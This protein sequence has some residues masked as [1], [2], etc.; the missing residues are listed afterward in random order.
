MKVLDRNLK[1][2][3]SGMFTNYSKFKLYKK[4][5]NKSLLSIVKSKNLIDK[6]I[7]RLGDF[8]FYKKILAKVQRNE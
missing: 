3:F 1:A 8:D 4:R 7:N 2:R 5:Q 6:V